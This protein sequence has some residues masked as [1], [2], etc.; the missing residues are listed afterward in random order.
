MLELVSLRFTLIAQS[1][2]SGRARDGEGVAEELVDLVFAG[3][4]GG[5]G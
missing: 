4:F 2:A 1:D 3:V 5:R